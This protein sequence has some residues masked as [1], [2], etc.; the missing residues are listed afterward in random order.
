MATV[1][2]FED[3]DVWKRARELANMIYDFSE[4][5]AFA[6]DYGLREQMRRAAISTLSNIAE[7]FESR[8]QALFIEFLGRTKGFA[9]ELRAQLYIAIDQ[10]YITQDQFDMSSKLVE[11]CS[12][13]ITR[14][15]QY[16]ETK[17]NARRIR[18][19]GVSYDV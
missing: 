18:E 13:Q 15:I 17:P 11:T 7:G 2:R 5:G 8:T 12:K 16:L 19:T 6:R 3:L 4:A 9:G 1:D 10:T 14:F